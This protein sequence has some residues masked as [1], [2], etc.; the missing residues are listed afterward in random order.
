[1]ALEAWIAEKSIEAGLFL[2]RVVRA[3]GFVKEGYE[4]GYVSVFG[5]ENF[6]G[7]GEARTGFVEPVAHGMGLSLVLRG[8]EL[9][10]ERAGNEGLSLG[11]C[12]SWWCGRRRGLGMA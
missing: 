9:G 2:L 11:G 10:G 1:V 6:L 7:R 12:E 3:E 8:A 5:F 4:T